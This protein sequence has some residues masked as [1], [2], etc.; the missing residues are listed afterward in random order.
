MLLS[1]DGFLEKRWQEVLHKWRKKA[2]PV[3]EEGS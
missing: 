2:D 3:L 1:A